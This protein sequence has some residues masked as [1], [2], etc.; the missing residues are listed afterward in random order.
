M[1]PR[2]LDLAEVLEIHADQIERYGGP[3]GIRDISLLQSAMAMP[4]TGFA[5]TYAHGSHF[6]MAAAYLFHIVRN[7]PFVDGNKRT[8]LGAALVFLHLN[9]IVIEAGAD[10]LVSMVEAVL[11][12][13]FD[14][15]R[16]ATW[17][18]DKARS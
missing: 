11:A 10:E 3:A 8:A 6:E 5:G 17:L 13:E 15:V 12:G 16:V 9:E 4:E 7:H 18:K 1:K 2:F 14:K